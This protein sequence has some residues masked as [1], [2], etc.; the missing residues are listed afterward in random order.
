MAMEDRH[1]PR[2]VDQVR[3]RCR[4]KR[5]SLSTD[6]FLPSSRSKGMN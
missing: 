5:Y 2:L 4:V 3:E 6:D 1:P